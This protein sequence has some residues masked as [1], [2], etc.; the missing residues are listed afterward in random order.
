MERKYSILSETELVALFCES[1]HYAFTE[2]YNRYSPLVYSYAKRLIK[3]EVIAKD[4]LQEVF[5]SIWEKRSK[6]TISHSIVHYLFGAIHRRVANE[7]RSSKLHQR[8]IDIIIKRMESYE[9]SPEEYTIKLERNALIE[10]EIN[11]LPE[12]M[13]AIINLSRSGD[14]SYKEISAE[15]NI[16]YGSIRNNVSA[17]TKI[18]KLGLEKL[19]LFF[20]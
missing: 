8:Y 11:R 19:H 10:E 1:D 14:Y 13:K 18:L 17:A 9:D 2:L 5:I 20:L 7:I 6:L 12:K 3:D 4:I 16:P 15:L